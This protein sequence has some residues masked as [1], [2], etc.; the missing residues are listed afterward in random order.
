MR[1]TSTIRKVVVDESARFLD[2]L[3][4]VNTLYRAS[5]AYQSIQLHHAAK[6]RTSLHGRRRA[7]ANYDGMS[8][9]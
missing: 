1:R 4:R 5:I 9:A 7:N 6:G 3:Q 8:R 2:R